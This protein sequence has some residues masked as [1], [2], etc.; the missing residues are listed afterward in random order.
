MPRPLIKQAAEELRKWVHKDEPPPLIFIDAPTAY[1][2]TTQAPHLY[3]SVK[4]VVSSYIHVLPM[5]AMVEEAYNNALNGPQSTLLREI[6]GEDLERRVGYQAMALGLS[7]KSP[8]FTKE[9]VYTTLHSF[10][11]NALRIPVAEARQEGRHYELPRAYI[12]NSL[13][14]FDEAHLYGGLTP[15]A[16]SLNFLTS[17][18][19]PVVVESA[20]MPMKA[21]EG[22]SYWVSNDY[23][24]K[25]VT[26]RDISRGPGACEIIRVKD[27]GFTDEMC[28]EMKWVSEVRDSHNLIEGVAEAVKEYWGME[29][30][31]LAVLN[32]P[33]GAVRTWKSLKDEG[34]KAALVHGRMLPEERSVNLELFKGGE[35]NAIVATQVIE[36]G[37]NIDADAVV[38]APAIP[39][40][41]IQRAG[42]AARRG[43][44]REGLFTLVNSEDGLGPY[45]KYRESVV[46]AV[47]LMSDVRNWRCPLDEG[48]NKLIE[49]EPFENPSGS[50]KL[51]ELITTPVAG[52]R[53]FTEY[54][55]GKRGVGLCS[56]D[57][58]GPDYLI[59]PVSVEDSEL[60]VSIS[61]L[62][63]LLKKGIK[64]LLQTTEGHGFPLEDRCPSF[65]DTEFCRCIMRAIMNGEKLSVPVSSEGYLRGIG[66]VKL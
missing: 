41:L 6:V 2:K 32:T 8:Y 10:M 14:V 9:V 36:A 21:Y 5:R 17:S 7:G 31:V 62:K 24:C 50:M 59:V 27:E 56:P 13:T 15:F 46:K 1:G 16:I 66:L 39:S 26:L 35:V 65:K 19:T 33:E 57:V 58:F 20:T 29:K 60:P 47:D 63:K 28:R 54:I 22:I 61:T 18:W 42:R 48:L 30:R 64:V 52:A 38:T 37:V 43:I 45:R 55:I 12:L 40:S 3:S 11:M 53:Y 25:I 51:L 34:I 44:K 49:V 4:E 23:A